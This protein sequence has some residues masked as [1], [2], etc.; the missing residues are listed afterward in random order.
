LENAS[1]FKTGIFPY[2]SAF[3]VILQARRDSTSAR[4]AVS[5]YNSRVFDILTEVIFYE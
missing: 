2:Y 5:M 4:D 1:I 3:I